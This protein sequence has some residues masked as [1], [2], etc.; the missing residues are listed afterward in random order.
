MIYNNEIETMP[1]SKLRKLQSERFARLVNYMYN[2]QSFYK[3][4]WDEKRIDVSK[5]KG[6]EDIVR[7]PFT[8]KNDLRDNYPFGLFAV[9][10]SHISRIHCS[11]G[12]AGKPTVVGYTKND[13][14]IFSEVV[15]RSL[16]CAGAKPGMTRALMRRCESVEM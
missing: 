13:L 8:Y 14:A 16:C 1:L 9:P 7:F 2:N 3:R 6:I 10:A 5:I 11:S 15:A 12:S 4:L